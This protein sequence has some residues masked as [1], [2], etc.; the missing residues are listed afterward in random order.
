MVQ[1][2]LELKILCFG[3]LCAEQK[4]IWEQYE[5]IYGSPYCAKNKT[6]IALLKHSA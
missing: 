4:Y 6:T 3:L 5:V 1:A 2:G